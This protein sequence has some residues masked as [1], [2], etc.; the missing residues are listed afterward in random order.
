MKS[1]FVRNRY[2]RLGVR[3]TA[4]A[5]AIGGFLALTFNPSALAQAVNGTI[6]GTVPQAANESIRI[7]G[8]AGYNRTVEAGTSGQYSVTLPV[9]T[10]TVSLLRN[11]EVVQTRTGVSPA[12]AGAVTVDF[13]SGAVNAQ[14]LGAVTVNANAIPPIDITSTRQV[15]TI[16]AQQLQQ[17]PLGRTAESIA[18]LAPGVNPGSAALAGGP[19]GTGAVTFGGASTA[20]NAY[21]I[22]GMLTTAVL[23]NQGGIGLPYGSIAQQQ[24]FTSGYGAK[25]GRSIGG[26]IAQIGKSGS[27]QW[28]FG[29][30]AQWSP[31][32]WHSKHRNNYFA[33]PYRQTPGEQPGDIYEYNGSDRT[34]ETVYDAYV[35]GPI[36]KD[37]LFFFVSAEQDK[38][39]GTSVGS[40]L[41]PVQ[42]T[43]E[44]H[45]PKAYAKLNWNIN[46][47]NLLT[48]TGLQSSFKSWATNYS[49]D[50]DK[51]KRTSFLNESITGKNVYRMWVANYTSYITDDLTLHA[52]FGKS[53]EQYYSFQPAYPGFDPSL[54]HISGADNQNPAFVPPGGIFN[55]QTSSSIGLPNHLAKAT[56]YRL[57]LDYRLGDHDLQVGIDNDVTRDLHDGHIPTGPGYYWS[58]GHTA[59]PDQPL[60]GVT[61]GDD[62]YVGP[63]DSNPA[64]A[65]GYYVSRV[66]EVENAATRVRERA[67]YVQ[68]RW[69]VTPR[70]LLSLGLRNDQF[71]N[72]D[73]AA[74]PYIRLTKPNWSPRIGFSWD[75][76]GDSSLKIFG[77]AGRYYLTLPSDTGVIMSAPVT[78]VRSYGTYT[79]IDQVTGEPIG[80]KPLPMNPAD[81]VSPSHQYGEAKD[82]KTI[83]SKNIRAMFSDNY[84][85]GM[86]QQFEMLNTQWVFGETGTYQ[87]LN[88]VIGAYDQTSNECAAGVRQGLEWMAE[89]CGQWTVAPLFINPGVTNKIYVKGPDE[90]LHLIN[91]TPE[92]QGFGTR[93]KR[94]Y[95]SL[96][97]SLTHAWDGKWFGKIDYVFSRL[98]GNEAGPVS[99]FY[100]ASGNISFLDASWAFPE[101]AYNANG[102]LGTDH[103]H[104]FKLYGA[105]A[106]D[107]EWTVGVS[108]FVRSGAPKTCRGDFGPNE[109]A[110]HGSTTYHWCF[111]K[112]SNPG[113]HGRM[114]WVKNVD[115]SVDFRPA[116]AGHKLDFKLQVFNAFNSQTPILLGNYFVSRATPYPTYGAVQA[117]QTPR[118]ARFSVSYD[119]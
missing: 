108:I 32:A 63:P 52:M 83:A 22:D 38:S 96:D 37:K 30:R 97:L 21:Y 100:E 111:G 39:L 88:R 74:K 26:V 113:S 8:G 103:K 5:L 85:L 82:A 46:E 106:I 114:P 102:V 35:S 43:Y 115:V 36:V 86:Q 118:S 95:Y 87:R 110:L 1:R 47:N 84:V 62:P 68:D 80:F 89:N 49:Y 17:L 92:D 70:L 13:T 53:R 42:G 69:Q 112:P 93:P 119:Y 99:A 45:R 117:R 48:L 60:L 29:V 79:G 61:P 4:L 90:E 65:G 58:Y 55:A 25:Y 72:Y 71:T 116:F 105:Y 24:T 56:S 18:L 19:L 98:Y 73:A 12:A 7:T 59:T 41:N 101:M 15:T 44:Y 31:T 109:I 27:N 107:P 33:N 76:H 9:G 75:V 6:H 51:R 11:G 104:T 34:M 67:Q 16:T 23:N 3:R 66:V 78:F 40:V 91:L 64:G 20:E 50:Y 14:N 28:H 94:R 10:Y 57:D 2:A 77:N 54:P 81:A